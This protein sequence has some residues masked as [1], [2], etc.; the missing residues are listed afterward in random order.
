MSLNF[1]SF[2]F[3][4]QSMYFQSNSFPREPEIWR[5]RQG[6]L[7][8]HKS[9]SVL[10]K[11]QKMFNFLGLRSIHRVCTTVSSCCLSVRFSV[12]SNG[13][14][15]KSNPWRVGFKNIQSTGFIEISK[16]A[17]VRRV[18]HSESGFHD[19]KRIPALVCICGFLKISCQ[20][21]PLISKT[22]QN[23]PPWSGN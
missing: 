9:S 20:I 13:K 7:H 10:K 21:F 3:A 22:F 23:R 5:H 1:V 11:A 14:M 6:F 19:C 4:Y 8:P 2:F 16:Q 15:D 12:D 17:I 18:S